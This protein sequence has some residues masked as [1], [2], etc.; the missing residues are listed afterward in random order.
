M[1]NKTFNTSLLKM[2]LVGYTSI[3]RHIF[4]PIK[5]K[6]S[7]RKHV[8]NDKWL[9]NLRRKGLRVLHKEKSEKQDAGTG[10]RSHCRPAEKVHHLKHSRKETAVKAQW[11]HGGSHPSMIPVPED[12]ASSCDIYRYAA[13]LHASFKLLF[14]V[15]SHKDR[16]YFTYWVMEVDFGKYRNLP[17]LQECMNY[18]RFKVSPTPELLLFSNT[19]SL[20]RP[21]IP[22]L[23]GNS[24]CIQGL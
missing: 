5:G 14:T 10:W 17:R 22:L 23:P 9:L 11:P 18:P 24:P 2:S 3:M 4:K 13:I 1:K 6:I 12:L 19:E 8:G 21:L 20:H 16:Y 7:Y 15:I